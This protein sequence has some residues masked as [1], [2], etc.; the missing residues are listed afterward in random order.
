[1]SPMVS[2]TDVWKSDG[3][4]NT[5]AIMLHYRSIGALLRD[6]QQSQ[7]FEACLF[8]T[9]ITYNITN[10]FHHNRLELG[11]SRLLTWPQGW[12]QEGAVE[13]RTRETGIREGETNPPP[14][15]VYVTSLTQPLRGTLF[16]ILLSQNVSIRKYILINLWNI[17]RL[18]VSCLCWAVYPRSMQGCQKGPTA[19]LRQLLGVPPTSHS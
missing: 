14:R 7:L 18:D 6:Y 4:G 19:A 5:M 8:S 16:K 15:H 13:G 1:M 9:I 11:Q 12:S 2:K 3:N 17:L 10:L